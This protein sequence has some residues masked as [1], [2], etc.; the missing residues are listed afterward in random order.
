M[1]KC[2]KCG[3]EYVIAYEDFK[4]GAILIPKAECLKCPKCGAVTRTPE[5]IK[6]ILKIVQNHEFAQLGL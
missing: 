3:V 5:Q 2:P 6:K 1:E 4:V